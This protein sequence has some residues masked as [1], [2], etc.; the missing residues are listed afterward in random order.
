MIYFRQIQFLLTYVR[1]SYVPIWDNK[2]KLQ[3]NPNY[4]PGVDNT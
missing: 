1:A 3:G 2:A 4:V